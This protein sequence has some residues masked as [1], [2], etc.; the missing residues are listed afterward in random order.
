MPPTCGGWK[1]PPPS[2][3]RRACCC[4]KM[5]NSSLSG[6]G[7]K[8]LRSGFREQGMPS[9]AGYGDLGAND[10]ARQRG[11][12]RSVRAHGCRL[13]KRR[14]GESSGNGVFPLLDGRNVAIG[15]GFRQRLGVILFLQLAADPLEGFPQV[16]VGTGDVLKRPVKDSLHALMPP[17]N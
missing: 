12:G 1:K 8:K 10:G 11:S 17:A 16:G 4:A 9:W 7:T 3:S 6:R 15:L 14:N 13:A 2:W 5:P